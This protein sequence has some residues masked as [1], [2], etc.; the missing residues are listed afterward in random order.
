MKAVV[1]SRYGSP[2]GLELREV[3]APVPR[4]GEVLVRVHATTVTAGDTE[5]RASRLPWLFWLPIRLWLG[6][7]RPRPNL[8][9][10]MEYAGVVEAI[11]EGVDAFQVGDAVMGAPQMG[12]GT[13]AEYVCVPA[14]GIITRKPASVGFAQAAA[15]PIGGLAALGYLRKGGLAAGKR[16]LVRG[17]SGSI[18][19]FAVQLAKHAGAHVTAICPTEGVDRARSL[20]AD[21][22]LDYTVR[23]FTETGETYDLMLDVVG[24]MPISRCLRHVA[25]GGSYVR[26]TI[27]G[28]WEVLVSLWVRIAS[29]KRVVMG[30]AGDSVEGLRELAGLMEQGVLEPVVD[31]EYALQDIRAA[32]SYVDTGHKQGNVVIGVAD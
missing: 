10:G 5:L 9:L 1:L 7:F 29:A 8:L 26:G 25:P 17:S 32:H 6:P 4:A 28:L 23:D 11:G 2:D 27:P 14:D 13:Y 19:T 31:R 22:V 18:G 16:V 12:L 3:D 21:E 30:D 15:V 24:K 20:G